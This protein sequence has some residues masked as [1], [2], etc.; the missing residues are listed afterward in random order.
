DCERALGRPRRVRQR[1][2]ELRQ[3]SPDPDLL[4]EARLVLAAT[5]AD[6]GDLAGAIDMLVE[7]GA[8]RRVRNPAPRHVRQWYLLAALAERSGDM[9]RARELFAR[10]AAVEPGAY[11]VEDRLAQ[12][13]GPTGR[14]DLG[15]R[16]DRPTPA[17][18]AA[19]PRGGRRAEG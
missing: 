13:G 7:A 15:R 12:L 8:G 3:A 9:A 14:R 2:E 5:M 18:S 6:T 16:R 19:R 17:A 11:D 1:F 4:A 10:V